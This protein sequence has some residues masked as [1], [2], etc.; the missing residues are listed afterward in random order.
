MTTASP[1]HRLEIRVDPP[2][3]VHVGTG[4][5]SSLAE[6]VGTAVAAPSGICVVTD[7]AVAPHHAEA[8]RATLE[9]LGTPVHLCVVPAGERT[10]RLQNYGDLLEALA[11]ARI[12]RGGLVVA[13]GGGVVGDLTG[14]AAATYMRGVAYVQVPTTLLAMVDSSVGGKTG[15][16]LPAG[17]NL[18]GAFWQPR[19]VV[20]DV[21]TLETLPAAVRRQG[22]VELFKAGLLGDPRLV[23][24]FG[25]DMDFGLVV[26]RGGGELAALIAR[27]VAVKAAVVAADPLEHGVRATLNLGHTIGHALESLSDHALPHGD[28]VAY[29]LLAAAE[30]G[31]ARGLVDWRPHA[32]RLLRWL[33][34]GPLP[35]TTATALLERVARDKKQVGARRRF[36]LLQEIGEPIVVDDVSDGEIT[37]AWQALEAVT[38]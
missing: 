19:A 1:V 3:L 20:A 17:K 34:P 2:Y 12:D 16:N 36:V 15:I 31:A 23:R 24:A 35:T 21:S 7:D 38:R 37:R 28:A 6:L 29:G 27:G 13:L 33:D 30:V 26:D 9:A 25:T 18:V 5:L 10:K 22:G 14:F 32:R 4:L 11:D 8:V